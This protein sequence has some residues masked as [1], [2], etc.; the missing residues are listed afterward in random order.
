MGHFIGNI[1]L[2][3]VIKVRN[4]IVY[5]NSFHEESGISQVA[6]SIKCYF[7]SQKGL[8]HSTTQLPS[9]KPFTL[10]EQISQF[11][12]L[13][14]N[15]KNRLLY[16]STHLNVPLCAL[17]FRNT[18]LIVLYYE[19][20]RTTP[21]ETTLIKYYLWLIFEF[22][23]RLNANVVLFQSHKSIYDYKHRAR[24][25]HFSKYVHW[26]VTDIITKQE[27]TKCQPVLTMHALGKP[28][29]NPL[30][31]VE[32]YKSIRLL[33]PKLELNIIVDDLF[34]KRYPD[35]LK[36]LKS[37]SFTNVVNMPT[38]TEY[39]DLLK[40]TTHYVLC[41]RTEYSYS[42]PAYEFL[43][44]GSTLSLPGDDFGH[45]FPAGFTYEQSN[46]KSCVDNIAYNLHNTVEEKL[47][48]QKSALQTD[49]NKKK[50]T[51]QFLDNIYN[52]VFK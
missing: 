47:G 12:F 8:D 13:Y 6:K 21:G 42:I 37:D 22:F 3:Q 17:L 33:H 52:I 23:V 18:F 46:V 39:Q 9:T 28:R 24:S 1:N 7:D 20:L 27:F 4:V 43:L 29:K 49:K 51:Y 44:N 41:S 50:C 40:D 36:F 14:R 45:L 2:F 25:N 16:I 19:D 32:V 34:G 11:L 48:L 38:R 10:K 5:D 15:R 30:F 35:Q 26:P 31:S